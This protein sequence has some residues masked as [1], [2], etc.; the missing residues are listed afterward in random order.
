M[1]YKL[2]D[3][4]KF[5]T[6]RLDQISDHETPNPNYRLALWIRIRIPLDLDPDRGRRIVY[7]KKNTL[8]ISLV[9]NLG[10]E[11]SVSTTT[12]YCSMRLAP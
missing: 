8:R 2:L 1:R 11:C 5:N 7:L 9:I 12:I 10:L 4:V 3:F 6:I